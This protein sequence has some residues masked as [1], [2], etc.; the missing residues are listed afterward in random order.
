MCQA[1][2]T[3]FSSFSLLDM[4]QIFVKFD[5]KD[6]RNMKPKFPNVGSLKQWVTR[7]EEKDYEVAIHNKVVLSDEAPIPVT[8]EDTPLHLLREIRE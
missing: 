7:K 4:A 6:F 8:S 5:Y 1:T 2:L 3:L